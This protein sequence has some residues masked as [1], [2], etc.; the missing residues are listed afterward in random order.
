[1]RAMVFGAGL[2][3]RLRP[4]TE[5][6]PKPVVP[7]FGKPLAGWTIEHLIRA[8]ATRVVVNTHHLA[9]RV[10]SALRDHAAS[11]PSSAPLLFSREDALLGTGGG[12]R[13]AWE[14]EESSRGVM[15]DDEIL[16]AVNGDILFAPPVEELV[17]E[18]RAR[19]ADATLI[20]RRVEDP[21]SLGAIEVDPGGRV[22]A[23]LAKER[24]HASGTP[25][26]FTGMH[27]LSRAALTRLPVE[28]CV[29]RQGY[30]PWLADGLRVFG[31]ITESP[32]LDLG[33]PRVY[34][35]A[36]LDVLD[37]RRELHG[38]AAG[39]AWI[40]P[41]VTIAD[42]ATISHAVIGAGATVAAVHVER[43]V[44]WPGARV[45]QAVRDAIV[46]PDGRV[47]PV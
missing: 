30:R 31:A 11:R 2:G 28:G 44:V 7:F 42:G 39:P 19:G 16:V 20:L 40:D 32:W 27:I 8:G 41:S 26:M 6:L 17:R 1:M 46:L 15:D 4:L 36:H 25:A 14:I 21:F 24:A 22:T 29:I 10:E 3:T 5:L 34:R 38:I 12:L 33:T 45:E 23:M 37:G 47:V 9:D 18:H 35:D 13:R 43:S